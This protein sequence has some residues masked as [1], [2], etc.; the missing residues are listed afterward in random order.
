MEV[1]GQKFLVMGAA[2][3]GQAVAAFLQKKGAH[4]FL[5]DLKE[6]TAFPKEKLALWKKRG[7]SLILGREPCLSEIKPVSVI[8]SPGVPSDLP[9]LQEARQRGLPVWSEIELAARFLKVP[10]LAV[11]GTNGKTTTTTLLGKILADSGQKVFVQGNIGSP[12][13]SVLEEIEPEALVVLE[14]SSFQLEATEQFQPKVA[15]F[16]NLAPDHLDRHQ[17]FLHYAQAKKRIFAAQGP[18]DY[19]LI[20]AADAQLREMAT[21]AQSQVLFFS[22]THILEEGFCLLEDWLVIREKGQTRRLLPVKELQ[23]KGKHNWENALAAA[24]AAWLMGVAPQ[25]IA[26]SLRDFRGIEHRLEPV[27]THRGISYVNDSKGTNPAAVLRALEAYDAPVVLIAGGQSKGSDFSSLAA[28]IKEKVKDLVLIGP[29]AVE[30]A[31]AMQ[32]V[33]YQRFHNAP[34]LATAV[35]K[36]AGLARAGD[37]VLL[38][39]ACAS[40]DAF[41]DFAQRGRVFKESVFALAEEKT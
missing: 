3:S 34:D 1:R 13:S 29:A 38:S 8:I 4:V 14:V 31:Q 5:H 30:I 36:A 28:Q 19:L 17:T 21:T 2:R 24:G 20:N 16:L 18:E 35:K 12:L 11:T 41:T 10:L 6:S 37:V 7:W 23:I 32:K 40:F 26:A 39:P 33:D 22:G 27:L 15:L 25:S 9:L